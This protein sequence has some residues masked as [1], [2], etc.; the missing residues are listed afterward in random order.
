MTKPA[1]HPED[2]VIVYRDPTALRPYDRNARTHPPAQIAKIRS[3][4]REF[5]FRNPV[6]LRDDDETIGAGHGRVEAAIEEGLER[7]PTITLHGLTDAQ[8][9]AYVI[10]DNRIALDGGWNLDILKAE[11]LDLREAGTALDVTGLDIGEISNLFATSKPKGDKNAVP[12]VPP[13]ATTRPGDVWL[14]GSHRL[15]CGDATSPEA[16]EA[17]LQGDRPE[18]CLTDPP[19]G[20]GYGYK[21]HDDS[22]NDANAV[23]VEKVFRL[24]PAAKV[25]SPGSNNLARDITRF[26]RAK[27]LYWHKGFAA[28]GNGLGGASTIEPFLVVGPPK[29]KKLPNDYLDFKTDRVEVAGK[30]LR[31]HHPCP[32]PVD[33][34]SHL[35]EAFCKKGGMIYEP[36]SGSGTTLIACAVAGRVCR[37]IEIDAAYVD[38]AVMR[39]QEFT[40][41][42]ARLQETGR[43]FAEV[44]AERGEAV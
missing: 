26:G 38:V 22:D 20:I 14:L 27:V 40:G 30:S 35:A 5:G 37:A 29:H 39:W 41:E 42:T 18:L 16:V 32:K 13:V 4:I 36:F 15:A 3:S 31:E 12:P 33:L 2:L 43:S 1:A 23:L 6:L 19:Y 8:W 25:W 11:L 21:D 9:K 10:A 7:I 17:L 34:F 24:A 44:V 28:A